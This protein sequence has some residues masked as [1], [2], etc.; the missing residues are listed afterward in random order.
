LSP[1]G[2]EIFEIPATPQR[3]RE[4]LRKAGAALNA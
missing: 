2:V 1:F 3:I 4:H